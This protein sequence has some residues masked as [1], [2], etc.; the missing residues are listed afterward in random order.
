LS[1]SSLISVLLSKIFDESLGCFVEEEGCA[2]VGELLATDG[3]GVVVVVVVDVLV[4]E[5]VV[6]R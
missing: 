3:S 6:E 4:V 1:P 5:V 2:V